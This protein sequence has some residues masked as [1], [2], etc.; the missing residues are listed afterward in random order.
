MDELIYKGKKYTRSNSKWVDSDNMF[1]HASLQIE[2]NKMYIDGMDFSRFN[3]KQL[4]GEG[5]KFK[6]SYTYDLAIAFY[7]KA[8]EKSDEE[9]LKYIL[10]RITSCYR[11]LKNPRKAIALFSY[12]KNKYGEEVL[13]IEVISPE[14]FLLVKSKNIDALLVAFMNGVYIYNE[15]YINLKLGFIKN[16]V[17]TQKLYLKKDILQEVK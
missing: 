12:A 11:M 8:V 9:L 15:I 2:L 6:K 16:D 1:V 3:V 17:F 13:G 14:E 10:P 7:E 4:V 5:D